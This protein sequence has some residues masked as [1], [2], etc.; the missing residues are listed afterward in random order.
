MLLIDIHE[1]D[2]VFAQPVALAAF[3]DQID[4]IRSILCLQGQNVL[5]LRTAKHLH[6][7]AQ[8]DSEGD[9]TVAAEG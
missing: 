5:V 8:V 1:F 2:V 4:N 3:E 6:E 7:R 9:V